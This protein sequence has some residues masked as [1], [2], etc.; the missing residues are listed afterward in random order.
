MADTPP[1]DAVC[2]GGDLDCGSGL[3]L[4]IRKAMDPL[5]RGG[6]LEIRS[7]E[8]SVREDLPAWCRMVGHEMAAE[9]PGVGGSTSYFV[10]KGGGDAG[11]G[12]DLERARGHS[13]TVRVR[14]NEGMRATAYA[15]NHSIP[16]GQP[17]S[18]DTADPAPAAVEVLL[19]SLGGCLA[20]GFQMRLSRQGI[21]VRNLEVSL[22]ARS[23]NLLVFLGAEDEGDPGLER[24]EGTVYVDADA[25]EA[26]LRAAWDETVRRSPVARSLLGKVPI[27]VDVRPA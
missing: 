8:S 16:L 4:L 10:R 24:V 23:G 11:L 6:V 18:L 17:A 19:A 9:A 13:W 1:A 14:W 5:S 15:R 25:D 3:L 26:R 22:R 2:E 21:A 20:V 27:A 7:R 12:D